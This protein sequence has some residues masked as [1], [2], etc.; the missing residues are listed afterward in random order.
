MQTF[1]V[2]S[3]K[4]GHRDLVF[5]PDGRT[6]FVGA[7]ALTLLDT[8]DGSSRALPD[9]KPYWGFAL[10]RGGTAV[11][12]GDIG[13]IRLFDL[14]GGPLGNC[15]LPGNFPHMLAG[16]ARADVLFVTDYRFRKPSIRVFGTGAALEAPGFGLE[17]RGQFATLQRDMYRL[18]LSADGRWLVSE[19]DDLM[20]VWN[21]GRK[22]LPTTPT[23]RMK[24]RSWY[25]VQDFAL[26]A[27]GALLIAVNSQGVE[28]WDAA[29]GKQ[30]LR[31]GKHR[32]GVTAVACHPLK[33]QFATGDTGGN[34][35]LW[36]HTGRVL[37]RFAW[38]LKHVCGLT[39]AP[40]GLRAAALGANG[41]VVIWD[42]DA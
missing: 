11:A 27:D 29:R 23:A 9:V 2:G 28:L 18:A 10:A 36:D 22:A 21:V 12:V 30:V 5:A 20:R 17:E 4:A 39:F 25:F 15:E 8:T 38:G 34:V 16:N 26:S 40:D 1:K 14:D 24:V 19:S 33:P 31:S 41:K 13:E 3:K 42:L 7:D 32:R 37:A 6:L 35:F